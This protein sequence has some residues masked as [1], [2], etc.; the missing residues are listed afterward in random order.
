M[1]SDFIPDLRPIESY[2]SETYYVDVGQTQRT[3]LDQRRD[4]RDVVALRAY[5]SLTV[6]A[7]PS[8]QPVSSPFFVS[9][10]YL[11][12]I[13]FSNPKAFMENYPI[14]ALDAQYIKES[15]VNQIG[16]GPQ[17]YRFPVPVPMNLA[18]SYIYNGG[19]PGAVVL[20]MWFD[21]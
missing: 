18:A 19:F 3:F 17:V 16:P 10:M 5:S 12:L 1:E 21:T 20:E 6:Q 2:Q 15:T 9:A 7:F 8:G 11:N 14:L 4:R 13:E